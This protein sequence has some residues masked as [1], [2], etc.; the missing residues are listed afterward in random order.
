MVGRSDPA[1]EL[2]APRGGRHKAKKTPIGRLFRTILRST[3]TPWASAPRSQPVR[4][5]LHGRQRHHQRPARVR[6]HR[7]RRRRHS[8]PAA[9]RGSGARQAGPADGRPALGSRGRAHRAGAISTAR[10]RR[11]RTS[12]RRRV[13]RRALHQAGG[14][15]LGE[16][17]AQSSSSAPRRRSRW[18]PSRASTIR[19]AAAMREKRQ[20]DINDRSA[21]PTAL[22]QR[23]DAQV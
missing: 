1:C 21:T 9:R 2:A 20:P 12:R 10:R 19:S 18:S 5:H 23:V 14:E 16:G 8:H 3:G 6:R 13:A 22:E 15:Q 7:R 17:H 11:S 4:R